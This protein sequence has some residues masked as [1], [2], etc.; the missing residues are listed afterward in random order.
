MTSIDLYNESEVAVD[1]NSIRDLIE[2][3]LSTNKHQ[4]ATVSIII[5]DDNTLRKM[6]KKYFN[7]DLY[8]DVI[9]FNF[10]NS[11]EELEGELYLSIDI[12]ENNANDYSVTLENEIKR[13]IAH[14]LLHLIGYLEDLGNKVVHPLESELI[15]LPK[16]LT[17]GR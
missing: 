13:V 5:T 11:D 14:G 6:K 1:H 12:I 3:V 9:A 10:N 17:H 2:L 4:S 8:T 7:Q 15:D 16:N